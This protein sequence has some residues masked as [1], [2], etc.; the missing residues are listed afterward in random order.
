MDPVQFRVIQLLAAEVLGAILCLAGLVLLFLGAS[1]K[2]SLLMQG[3]GIKTKLTNA[4]P[5]LVV[6]VIGLVLIAFSLK[7]SV[8]R[9]EQGPVVDADAILSDFST[10]ASRL[11]SHSG[12][13]PYSAMKDAI[14]GTNPVREIVSS[15]IHLDKSETLAEVSKDTY[16]REDYWPLI[17]AINMDQGYYDFHKATAETSVPSGRYLEI[18]KI[19]K[20]FGQT[21]ETILALS[22]PPVARANEEILRLAQQGAPLDIP[23]LQ[24]QYKAKEL[25]LL[26]GEAQ[27]S[28]LRTVRELAIK[29]YGDAKFWPILVWTNP[30]SLNG[31]TE[32]TAIPTDAQLQVLHF[33]E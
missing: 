29:Y 33:A 18:W 32:D 23:A 3:P 13:L 26:Y 27:T 11:R 22:G 19:S 6:A 12:E 17:A 10:K 15:T 28:H 9:K 20:N 4:S 2:V 5:G 30:K 24:D 21:R 1:G 31:A 8:K 16:G 14:L 7:G 25:T